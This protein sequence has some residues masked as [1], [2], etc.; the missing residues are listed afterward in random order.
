MCSKCSTLGESARRNR[1]GAERAEP[2][3]F[4][5]RTE[6]GLRV[7][8]TPATRVIMGEPSQVVPG[9]L[10][11]VRGKRRS[12]NEVDAERLVILTNVARM[13]VEPSGS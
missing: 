13:Q 6:H 10:L 12:E 4:F 1:R 9:A 5:R 2:F 7:H 11:R 3:S 8:W